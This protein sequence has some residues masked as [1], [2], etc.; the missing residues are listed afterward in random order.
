VNSRKFSRKYSGSLLFKKFY[1]AYSSV[2]APCLG[3]TEIFALF[4]FSEKE[5]DNSSHS[6]GRGYILFCSDILR[7]DV[8]VNFQTF[9]YQVYFLMEL[10]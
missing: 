8:Q 5:V 10:E 4:A 9:L 7:N 3:Q 2:K 6:S 1:A